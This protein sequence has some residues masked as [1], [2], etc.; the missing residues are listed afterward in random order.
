MKTYARAIDGKI[1]EVIQPVIIDGVEIPIS[2]RFHPDFVNLLVEIPEELINSEIE[3][4]NNEVIK[5]SDEDL[6]QELKADKW[7]EIKEGRRR[8]IFSPLEF[9]GDLYDSDLYSQ[10]LMQGAAQMA[11]LATGDYSQQWTLLN[12]ETKELSK[13]D[14]IALGICLGSKISGCFVKSQTLRKLIK[15]SQTKEELTSIFW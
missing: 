2:E 4:V 15:N 5:K 10:Q 9:K 1:I 13:S 14:I 12:N 11:L 8:D 6:L 7:E 3:V